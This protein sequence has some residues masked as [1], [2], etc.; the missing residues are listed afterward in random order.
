[1][2]TVNYGMRYDL[3]LRRPALS[4]RSATRYAEPDLRTR[5]LWLRPT[6]KF[7]DG[8]GVFQPRFGFTCKPT[9]SLSLR[10]GGGIFGGRHAGR[11]CLEQLLEHRHADQLDHDNRAGQQQHLYQHQPARRNRRADADQRQRHDHPGGGRMPTCSNGNRLGQLP[12]NALDPEFKLP[13]QWRAT[14]SA[15]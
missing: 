9:S 2:L 7:L 5:P 14:L 11:L 12:V 15:D 10:G 4:G 6:S 8:L 1:M 13:S 3:Y